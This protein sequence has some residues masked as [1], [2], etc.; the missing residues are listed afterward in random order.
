VPA[1]LAQRRAEVVA[2]L[3][4]LEAQVKPIT[5]FLSNED[6]VKLLKQ[7]KAQNM[8]FLSKE[9][10]IGACRGGALGAWRLGTA[11]PGGRAAGRQSAEGPT[12]CL[13][14]AV[15]WP[16][17][18]AAALQCG[19]LGF[20]LEELL[21]WK[22]ILK[23]PT[24]AGMGGGREGL[25]KAAAGAGAGAGASRA[26]RGLQLLPTEGAWAVWHLSL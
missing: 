18:G 6:N 14:G 21:L 22:G 11:L 25:V 20:L 7:D 3:K 10:N 4:T 16:S 9:F 5:E 13:L 24:Q 2:R 12:G 19:S 1:S 26:C 23:G 8:A 15:W 17:E